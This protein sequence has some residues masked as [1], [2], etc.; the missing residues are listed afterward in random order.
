MKVLIR[1]REKGRVG[2]KLNIF[3]YFKENKK[4][5]LAFLYKKIKNVVLFMQKPL[6]VV[7]L[8]QV[9][10]GLLYSLPLTFCSLFSAAGFLG[11]RNL[12]TW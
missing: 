6:M 8:F 5:R 2:Q 1:Y 12:N 7:L 4:K 10:V 9:L 11:F 3:G